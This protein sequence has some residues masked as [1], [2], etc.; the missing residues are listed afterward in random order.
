[1][2]KAAY[3]NERSFRE[4]AKQEDF[5]AGGT[6]LRKQFACDEVRTINEEKRTIDFIISTASNDRM[7]DTIAVDGWDLKAYKKNPVVLFA[8][9]SR[10]PPIGKA[11]NIKKRSEK[12]HLVARAEFTPEEI[13]PF[14]FSIFQLYV[15]GFMKAVSVGFRPIQ[16]EFADDEKR[17]GGI[18]FLKQELLEFSAVPVPAN[19][20]ALIEA[21]SVGID[22]MPLKTWAERILDEH[23]DNWDEFEKQGEVLVPK[24]HIIALR[25]HADKN[26]ATSVSLSDQDDI[27]KKNLRAIKEAGM[28]Q[29][30]KNIKAP[31]I[32]GMTNGHQHDY[33]DAEDGMTMEADGHSHP[34]TTEASP[35]GQMVT[36]GEANGHTHVADPA[37]VSEGTDSGPHADADTPETKDGEDADVEK[38]DPYDGDIE[39]GNDENSDDKGGDADTSEK[40]SGGGT[41][42]GDGAE[43][44]KTIDNEKDNGG[45]EDEDTV[46]PED[47]D[48]GDEEV[49]V[50]LSE[51]LGSM[52]DIADALL[53]GQLDNI[54]GITDTR[55]GKRLV[56]NAVSTLR[57]LTDS[58]ES[59]ATPEKGEEDDEE[60]GDAGSAGAADKNSE[61]IDKDFAA[62]TDDDGNILMAPEEKTIPTDD[63][64]KD[65]DIS[66]LITVEAIQDALREVI[67]EMVR[68]KTNQA[69]GR[70]D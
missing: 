67:P 49:I 3:V 68:E 17:P 40:D 38:E 69:L 43:V 54:K 42:G 19:P 13:N 26:G 60:K 7:N 9:D 5:D 55:K 22:T 18:D 52:I 50:N 63:E 14:G 45:N 53:D 46:A 12:G 31:R 35:E 10:E 29:D 27:L 58:L 59:H 36:I 37:N 64:E 41:E 51:V 48:L 66:S 28:A 24:R 4:Q 1:M 70:V 32:T 16:L 20:E 15:H 61:F 34:I 44:E 21:R 2:V 25:K 33:N 47:K 11:S 30:D 57:E 39:A 65:V 23:G 56:D 62:Y 6:L 8:H